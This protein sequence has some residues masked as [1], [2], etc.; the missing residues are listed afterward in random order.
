LAEETAPTRFE[1][2]GF[3]DSLARPSRIKIKC[4]FYL[5]GESAVAG[6]RVP[7]RDNSRRDAFDLR[8]SGVGIS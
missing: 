6:V 8:L 7:D 3:V 2:L 1:G 5:N 4:I